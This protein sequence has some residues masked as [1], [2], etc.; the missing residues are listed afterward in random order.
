MGRGRGR[1][2]L[3]LSEIN[4]VP[5]VDVMLVLLIIF[6]LAYAHDSARHR[7]ASP[8][9]APG[10]T[11]EGERLFVTIPATFRKDGMVFVGSDQV[12][13]EVM[14]ERVRQKLESGAERRCTSAATEPS[15]FRN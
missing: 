14:Q 3:S 4:V 9:G 2:V 10:L 5:L 6:A 15:R 12:R 11:V 8:R 1:R 7:R 13:A